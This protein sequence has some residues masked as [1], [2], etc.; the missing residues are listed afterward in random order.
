MCAK[1]AERKQAARRIRIRQLG[2]FL[3]TIWVLLCSI[4]IFIVIL[5]P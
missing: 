3:K 4:A 1:T 2:I 5:H